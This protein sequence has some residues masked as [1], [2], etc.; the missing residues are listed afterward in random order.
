[1]CSGSTGLHDLKRSR[2]SFPKAAK[3]RLLPVSAVPSGW[4]S[5]VTRQLRTR[6]IGRLQREVRVEEL[7]QL[8]MRQRVLGHALAVSG[9]EAC[10]NAP[11]ET[12][13]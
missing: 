3:R 4:V 13:P 5:K 7:D 2:K 12:G 1:M 11:K 9:I 10:P 6:E 8:V